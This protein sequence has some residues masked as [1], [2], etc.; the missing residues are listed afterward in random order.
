MVKIPSR[1]YSEDELMRQ[2]EAFKKDDI[3]WR[4]G[5]TMGYIYNPGLKTEELGKKAYTMF[6]T[7]NALDPTI[8]QS[9]MRIEKDLMGMAA[10]HLGGDDKVVGTF[11]SGGTESILLAVKTARDFCRAKHPT[12]TQPEMVLPMTAHA[13]FYKAAEYFDIT[14]VRV[15]VD[16]KSFRADA[17]QMKDA[18][19]D[20]TILIVGSAPSYAHGVVDPIPELGQIAIDHG[21]LFHVDACV[22]GFM[23]PYYRRLGQIFPDFDFTVPGVTSISMDFHKY[24]Y[25]PKNASIVLYRTKDLRRFQFFACAR[26]PGYSV[27]NSAVQSSK[28]GGPLAAAWAVVKFLGDEGYLE[29][30]QRT[31][32]ATQRIIQ[33]IERIEG[34]RLM[35]RPDLC[36]FSFTSDAIDVF[37]IIDEMK[38]RGWYIQ[39]QLTFENSRKNIHISI[40]ESN[41]DLAEEFLQD[42][43]ISVEN[44]KSLETTKLASEIQ[45]LITG[46]GADDLSDQ[47]ISQMMSLVGVEGDR[48]PSRMAEINE[49][50]NV[51]P[52][53]LRERLLIGFLNDLFVQPQ[54]GS[55][56]DLLHESEEGND[57]I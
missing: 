23:L 42:L 47:D 19:T 46:G 37:H 13:A 45:S 36:M 12:I 25:T 4:S 41:A 26:W 35:A 28:T 38:V 52:P 56:E 40:N 54:E 3:D 16:E 49:I 6:L 2:L 22:G 55:Q 51:L 50:L 31:R 11:T 27:I 44:A 43:K 7:E 24:G 10:S 32:D 48:M 1:G 9:L 15:P 14:P 29:I 33:G 39:P 20:Q 30:A 34:L 18:I 21:V 17:S 57:G 5:R 8:F 53:S